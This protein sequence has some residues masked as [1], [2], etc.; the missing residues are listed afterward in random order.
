MK[1]VHTP[2]YGILGSEL[3]SQS[4]MA[5]KKKSYN[6]EILHRVKSHKKN[7]IWGEKKVGV[8][9]SPLGG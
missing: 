6:F 7:K 4:K 8:P 9:P 2:N 5:Q 3:Q 1:N